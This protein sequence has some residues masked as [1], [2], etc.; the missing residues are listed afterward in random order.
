LKTITLLIFQICTLM[1][2]F[3]KKANIF[4]KI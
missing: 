1:K 2:L 4:K 3:N